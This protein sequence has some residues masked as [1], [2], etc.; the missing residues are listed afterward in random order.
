MRNVE[1]LESADRLVHLLRALHW[2][3]GT[4]IL[5]QGSYL[6]T[7][8][9]CLSISL[10]LHPVREVNNEL[11]LDDLILSNVLIATDLFEPL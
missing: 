3:P 7:R 1:S 10:V 5:L 2:C 6:A 11:D 9:K 8:P 4:R